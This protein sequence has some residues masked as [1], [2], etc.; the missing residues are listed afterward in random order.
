[1]RSR[2]KR[3]PDHEI[4]IPTELLTEI[5]ARLPVK[6]LLRFRCVCKLWCSL[7]DSQDFI[8]MH[9]R[10]FQNNRSK[11]HLLVMEEIYRANGEECTFA[12]R[13]ADTL[14]KTAHLHTSNNSYQIIATCNG[15][16]LL[17]E[18]ISSGGSDL[19][20]WNP[21]IRKA[22]L[23]P[24]CP[25]EHERH[26]LLLGFSPFSNDY[27]LVVFR[28][29]DGLAQDVSMSI[30]VYSLRNHSWKVN[31]NRINVPLSFMRGFPTQGDR[32]FCRGAI[33][34]IGRDPYLRKVKGNQKTHLVSFN[35]D[36]EDFISVELPDTAKDWFIFLLGESVAVSS[37]DIRN[38]PVWVLET[39][40]G[41]RKDPRLSRVVQWDSCNAFKGISIFLDSRLLYNQDSDTFIIHDSN[42][43]NSFNP[44][45]RQVQQLGKSIRGTL[46][47]DT[48]VESLELHKGTQGHIFSMTK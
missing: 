40:G 1:M 18:R 13:R 48:Y 2:K 11:T 3:V 24:A 38:S 28:Y 21:S 22:L 35:F 25:S 8:D 36:S 19:R 7:I 4:H 43:V 47:L 20:L 46:T 12:I 30:A 27:K 32:V 34:W 9:L 16:V 37:M 45:T 26:P 6:T 31:V 17:W 33:Y 14:R 29:N 39:D 23:L 15:L 42:R 41:F 5:L 10:L 44:T